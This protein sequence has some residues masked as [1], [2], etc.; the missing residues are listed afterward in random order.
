MNEV[1]N[2]EAC[3]GCGACC[4][5]MM[6]PPFDEEFDRDRVTPEHLVEEINHYW[7]NT[8]ND[9]LIGR[10]CLWFDE[11]KKRCKHYEHRPAICRE[12]VPGCDVCNDDRTTAGLPLIQ[13]QTGKE[14]TSE[15]HD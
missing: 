12:F 3:E 13:F 4:H 14:I 11:E 9:E 6:I 8:P 10:P 5:H 15:D 1:N 2:H 7:D